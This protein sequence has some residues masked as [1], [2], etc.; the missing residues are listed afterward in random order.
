MFGSSKK[1]A[2]VTSKQTSTRYENVLVMVH[3][4][5]VRIPT[6][7]NRK[8]KHAFRK[9]NWNDSPQIEQRKTNFLLLPNRTSPA[10]IYQNVDIRRLRFT[11]NGDLKMSPN[12]RS[13]WLINYGAPDKNNKDQIQPRV[14]KL[15]NL[16]MNKYCMNL[17]E[18][19]WMG[20]PSVEDTSVAAARPLEES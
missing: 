8:Q 18:N 3:R 10:F 2:V 20:Q 16:E 6:S 14:N 13:K 11:G 15:M 4:I 1:Y 12:R 19:Q 7:N 17:S 9:L 5:S